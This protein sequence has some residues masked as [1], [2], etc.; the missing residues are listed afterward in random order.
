MSQECRKLCREFVTSC[1]VVNTENSDDSL[2]KNVLNPVRTALAEKQPL[3]HHDPEVALK[4]AALDSRAEMLELAGRDSAAL[5][6]AAKGDFLSVRQVVA[7]SEDILP[8]CQLS[9]LLDLSE[10]GQRGRQ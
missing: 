3:L 7:A 1:T 5:Q 2:H 8:D 9:P 4:G 6:H 10:L